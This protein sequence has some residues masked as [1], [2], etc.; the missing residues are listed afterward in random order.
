MNIDLA[1]LP[2]DMDTLHRMISDLMSARDPEWIETQV[3][4]DRLRNPGTQSVPPRGR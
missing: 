4:I 3:E 1:A 2:D